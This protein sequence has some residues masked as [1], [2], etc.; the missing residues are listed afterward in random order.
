MRKLAREA[1]VFGLLGLLMASIGFF[2][3]LYADA[4]LTARTVAAQAVHA[5][6]DQVQRVEPSHAIVVVT[7]NDG[8]ILHVRQC[9]KYDPQTAYESADRL[10]AALETRSLRQKQAAQ[11]NDNAQPRNKLALP[12]P[13]ETFD[14][15]N[16]S[17]T[18]YDQ[19]SLERDYWT[20]YRESKHQA[21]A[22]NVLGSLAKG[23]LGFPA[24]LGVWIFYR[25][26]QNSG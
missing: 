18:S 8:T 25:R 20:A 17:S 6:D 5:R 22:G 9:Q 1:G 4:R 19:A 14:C 7:L 26:L 23:L 15:R 21:L 11:P 12:K 16:F 3:K 24:G 2:A 10:I 13:D